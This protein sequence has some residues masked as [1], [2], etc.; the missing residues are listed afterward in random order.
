MTDPISD[1]TVLALQTTL[2]RASR[3]AAQVASN[4]AN[5]DTPGYR[6]RDVVFEEPL[7]RPT[8]AEVRRTD[9]GH[10]A[11]A[12]AGPRARVI[13]APVTRI[14]NDANTVDVDREMTRLAALQ[15]RY[16]AAA[17]M[18]RR[19]LALLAYTATDGRSG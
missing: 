11:G 9:P 17:D 5:L 16:T 3:R 13:E 6:A 14:R 15:G 7:G 18:V 19:R 1:A 8:F 2:G 4:L 12:P 10:L